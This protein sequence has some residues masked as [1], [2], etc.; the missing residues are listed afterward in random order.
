M[1]QIFPVG[2]AP[3]CASGRKN[4]IQCRGLE[5]QAG[6]FDD[7]LV[8]ALAQLIREWAPDPAPVWATSV[9]STRHPLL[10]PSLAERLAVELG[11]QFLPI[12]ERT[13]DHPVQR[14]QQNS[15]HQQ[16][17]VADAFAITGAVPEGSCLLVDDVV[18]S[19]W[20]MT[21]VGRLLRRSGSGVVYPVVLASSAG[22]Q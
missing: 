9:P 12:V 6:H 4:Y 2:S 3:W 21:E 18:D 11:L 8:E 17:N 13:A 15:M 22:R 7:Q 16:L 19:G 20:T 1:V 5:A 10:V 14:E